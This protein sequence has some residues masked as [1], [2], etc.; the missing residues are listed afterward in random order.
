MFAR[1]NRDGLVAALVD[2]ERCWDLAAFLAGVATPAVNERSTPILRSSSFN[3]CTALVDA[4]TSLRGGGFGATIGLAAAG[5]GA[6]S[7]CC[8]WQDS[9]YRAEALSW[10]MCRLVAANAA[11]KSLDGK[12]IRPEENPAEEDPEECPY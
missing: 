12:K 10:V 5:F 1:L 7:S 4:G 11:H 2:D 3:P 6:V 8:A 9:V